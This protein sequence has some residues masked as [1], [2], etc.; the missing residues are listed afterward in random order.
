[1]DSPRYPLELERH[2]FQLSS[3]VKL[4]TVS[5]SIPV[6]FSSFLDVS[7][8]ERLIFRAVNKDGGDNQHWL[9]S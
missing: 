7:K 1:M 6:L 9:R 3:P 2:C 4:T 5:P 8:G